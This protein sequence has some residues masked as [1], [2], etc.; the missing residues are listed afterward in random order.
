MCYIL[1]LRGC[2]ICRGLSP[3]RGRDSVCQST[4]IIKGKHKNSLTLTTN[5]SQNVTEP[6]KGISYPVGDLCLDFTKL[7]G[8]SAYTLYSNLIPPTDGTNGLL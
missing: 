4:L 6:S 7:T 3:N 8:S 2:S 5:F 1:I